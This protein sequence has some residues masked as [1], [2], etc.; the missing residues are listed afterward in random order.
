M[1]RLPLSFAFGF[2]RALWPRLNAGKFVFEFVAI[3]TNDV[4]KGPSDSLLASVLN[5]LFTQL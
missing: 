1:S 5:A 2:G 4:E 3:C